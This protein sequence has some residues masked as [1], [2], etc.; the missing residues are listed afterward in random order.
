[1]FNSF[2][3]IE[4]DRVEFRVT[5]AE[6]HRVVNVGTTKVELMQCASWYRDAPGYLKRREASQGAH[7]PLVQPPFIV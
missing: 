7:R 6:H 2:R 3:Q 4:N 5:T 1:V